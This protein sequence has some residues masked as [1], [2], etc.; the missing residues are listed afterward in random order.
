MACAAGTL[1]IIHKP[2]EE[3]ITMV[4]LLEPLLDRLALSV[5]IMGIIGAG[6]SSVFPIVM[7]APLLIGDYS[8]KPINYKAPLFRILTGVAMLFGLIVPVFQAR[9]V[10]AMLISQLFQIFVLP[11]V[12][13]AIM[14]L[15][16]RKDLLGEHKAGIWLNMGLILTFIF[17]ILISYQSVI[18]LRSSFHTMF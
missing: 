3:V 13:L 10:F 14:Y 18:G 9:P 16:N 6:L 17:S 4:S 11:V 1:H 5:F 8:N 12:V 2:V 15:L 7:L